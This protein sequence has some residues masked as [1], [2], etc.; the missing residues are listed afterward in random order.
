MS[1]SRKILAI[2]DLGRL[3]RDGALPSEDGALLASFL[4]DGDEL[5]FEAIVERHGSMVLGV[6]RRL[7]GDSNDA[8]EGFQATFLVLVR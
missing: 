7:L 5:A 8:D 3:F 1:A 4:E 6:C 2:R